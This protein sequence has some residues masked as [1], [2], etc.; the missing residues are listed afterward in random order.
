[1]RDYLTVANFTRAFALAAAMT[2]MAL[3]RLAIARPKDLVLNAAAALAAMILVSGAATAWEKKGGLAGLFPSRG[4]MLKGTVLA[5]VLGLAGLLIYLFWLDRLVFGIMEA[6]LDSST[7]LLR[8]PDTIWGGLAL[9]LWT[10][11]FE[12]MFFYAATV[13][14]W[15]KVFNNAYPAIAMTVL[16]RVFVTYVQVTSLGLHDSRG[17]FLLGSMFS[18]I[19][20]AFLFARTGL[21]SAMIFNGL[22]ALHLLFPR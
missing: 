7:L 1:M 15:S 16:G 19:V 6:R 12:T 20:S 22:L 4:T 10:A 11:G 18:A 5:S 14:F 17:I 3:P 8:Y 13:S 21:V 2:V 9:V